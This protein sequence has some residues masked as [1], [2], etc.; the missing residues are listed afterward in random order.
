MSSSIR[1]DAIISPG[2]LQG[3]GIHGAEALGI[4]LPMGAYDVVV[5][6]ATPGGI[7]AAVA[8][9]MEGS[10]VAIYEPSD[11]IGGMSTGGLTWWDVNQDWPSGYIYGLGNRFLRELADEYGVTWQYFYR[12]NPNA[13][14]KVVLKKFKQWL[15][16]YNIPV[17]LGN[18]LVSVSKTG[19][20]VTS[21]LFSSAGK[22]QAKCFVDS[23]YTGDLLAAAGCTTIIGRESNATYGETYNGVNVPAT[24]GQYINPVDPYVVAGVPSSGLLYGVNPKV[25]GAAGTADDSTMAFNYR[26]L[27]TNYANK[28]VI[29]E[30]DNYVASQYEVLGRHAVANGSGWTSI[31]DVVLLYGVRTSGVVTPKYDANHLGAFSLDFI[32]PQCTEYVTATPARRKQIEYN[33][34]QYIL[35]FFKFLKT[36]TRIPV[37][38]RNSVALWGFAP[39]EFQETGGFS[40]AIYVREGR[41]LI[42][43][44][45]MKESDV[46][47]LNSFVDDVGCVYYA[48]DDHVH[49]RVVVGGLVKNEGGVHASPVAGA[50][51]PFRIALPKAAECTNLMAT[52]C[53][54]T[55]HVVMRTIRME[56]IHMGIGD[57]VGRAAAMC[58]QSGVAVQQLDSSVVRAKQDHW[59]VVGA[60]AVLSTDARYNQGSMTTTGTWTAINYTE[61]HV[62]AYLGSGYHVSS[63]AS[64]A[65][66]FSPNLLETASYKV[67]AKW[68]DPSASASGAPVRSRIT[69]ITVSHAA[70]SATVTVDQNLDIVSNVAGDC[71]DWCYLGTYVFRKGAPSA[72]FVSV[73]TDGAGGS[74]IIGAIKWVKA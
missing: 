40:P 41:R 68:P 32:D 50:R 38:V 19:T 67:Y 63:T 5:Y 45:V 24:T 64:S 42:G 33:A 8:A 22:V 70:G 27:M 7:M 73:A 47:A 51:I 72:D 29:P 1:K 17:F 23:S 48:L 31:A 18:D 57:A 12:A 74:T 61:N 11:R 66:K 54:S 59:G 15:Q 20:I 3:S 14:P 10:T 44:F 6:G 65:K 37:A 69:P 2:D 35:G 60:A 36:D 39:D 9:A 4:S 13:E 43:D 28:V 53:A 21:A 16:R 58:A 52:F 55:S 26:L 56:P 34:K 30:P 49:Q 46:T 71:G 62:N 25:I